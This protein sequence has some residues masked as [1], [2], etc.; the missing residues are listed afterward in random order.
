MPNGAPFSISRKQMRSG[1]I[2]RSL[3]SSPSCFRTAQRFSFLNSTAREGADE[4]F[5]PLDREVGFSES[6]ERR[7]LPLVKPFATCRV[8]EMIFPRKRR[9]PFCSCSSAVTGS[10]FLLRQRAIERPMHHAMQAS[11]E[12]SIQPCKPQKVYRIIYLENSCFEA[13]CEPH[14]H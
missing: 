10:I 7:T 11:T 3:S 9:A 12:F 2:A 4:L 6:A 8:T 13:G 1:Q 5:S 14:C